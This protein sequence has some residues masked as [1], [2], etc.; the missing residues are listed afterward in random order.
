M[1]KCIQFLNSLF[2]EMTK[3]WLA[4]VKPGYV[5][6]SSFASPLIAVGQEMWTAFVSISAAFAVLFQPLYHAFEPLFKV[7]YMVFIKTPYTIF[8]PAFAVGA[9][10]C[11][12]CYNT[13]FCHVVLSQLNRIR[14]SL[15]WLVEV[16]EKSMKLD[17][18][19]AQ[20]VLMRSTV[21]NSGKALSL[22]LVYIFK[23][24]ERRVWL[25]IARPV[26]NKDDWSVN[27]TGHWKG[28]HMYLF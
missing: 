18:F 1:D 9:K 25:M 8:Q 10:C 14:G 15:G 7:I 12:L 17:P 21:I 5:I 2:E 16:L 4:Y 26:D 27:K 28:C 23:S 11:S 24:I 6:L 13:V 3:Q 19:K 22:G 20:L